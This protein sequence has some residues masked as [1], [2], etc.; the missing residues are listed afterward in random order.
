M[1]VHAGSNMAHG[2]SSTEG[3]QT[4]S[5]KQFIR[6]AQV[7]G[8]PSA[9]FEPSIEHEYRLHL[10]NEVSMGKTFVGWR[11][12]GKADSG[13]ERVWASECT[14]STMH[15]GFVSGINDRGY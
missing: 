12:T 5:P 9:S 10:H 6:Q 14:Y 1:V 2:G 13:K 15:A 4:P 8:E 11:T 3:P 7:V